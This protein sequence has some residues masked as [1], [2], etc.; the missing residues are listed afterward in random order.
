M[1]K[2]KTPEQI[3]T[4]FNIT[5]E[6]GLAYTSLHSAYD[7]SASRLRR[8]SRFER[9]MSGPRSESLLS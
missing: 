5:N 3:R 7:D 2:G 1:I 6:Y 4:L 9:R 8:R